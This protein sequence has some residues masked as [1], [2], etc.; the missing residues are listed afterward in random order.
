M[1][2]VQKTMSMKKPAL[3][4]EVIL[5]QRWIT[6]ININYA[7]KHGYALKIG[8]DLTERNSPYICPLGLLICNLFFIFIEFFGLSQCFPRSLSVYLCL[9]SIREYSAARNIILIHISV[10][11]LRPFQV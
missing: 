10:L 3:A 11:G 9:I 5:K 7:T 2:T 4:I 1:E 6:I 8:M